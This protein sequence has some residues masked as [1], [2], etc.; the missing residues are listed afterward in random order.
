MSLY[1]AAA[2]SAD[3]ERLEFLRVSALPS[4]SA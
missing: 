4:W 3:V 1:T 2:G